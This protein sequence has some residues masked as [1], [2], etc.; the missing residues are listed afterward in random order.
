[1]RLVQKKTLNNLFDNLNNIFDFSQKLISSSRK[2]IL[3]AYRSKFD[4]QVKEDS[5]P[6]TLIDRRVEKKLR[7]LIESE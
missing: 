4:V 3:K 2:I 5:S 6:V 1:M 7:T